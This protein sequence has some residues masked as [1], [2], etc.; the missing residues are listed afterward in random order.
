MYI[1]NYILSLKICLIEIRNTEYEINF[2]LIY[3][4]VFHQNILNQFFF[5]YISTM[6]D[7][8][9]IDLFLIY[10]FIVFGKDFY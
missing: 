5:P 6:F 9:D 1:Y 7:L 3:I 2:N 4:L 10:L 8:A